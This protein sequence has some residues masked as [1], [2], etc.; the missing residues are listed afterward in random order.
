MVFGDHVRVILDVAERGAMFLNDRGCVFTI[1]YFETSAHRPPP[2]TVTYGGGTGLD[3]ESRLGGIVGAVSAVATAV[4]VRS[5]AGGAGFGG[6]GAVAGFHVGTAVAFVCANAVEA[7]V[8]G[9]GGVAAG[10]V[11]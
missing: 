1:R 9:G 11:G 10:G 3:R 4:S 6:D 5:G 8:A 7:G 2:S